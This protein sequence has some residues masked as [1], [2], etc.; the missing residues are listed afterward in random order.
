MKHTSTPTTRRPLQKCLVFLM[1]AFFSLAGMNSFAH[2]A[3]PFQ[4][5]NCT[6]GATL[7]VDATIVSADANTWYAWQYKDNTGTWKCFT[8]S[9]VINGVTFTGITGVAATGPANNAP[10]L[11]I[12]NATLALEGVLVRVLM[13]DGASPCTSPANS[14]GGDGLAPHEG[15]SVSLHVYANSSDCGATTPGCLNNFLN[16]AGAYYGGFEARTYSSTTDSYT[17]LNFG[18]LAGASQLSF[19][20]GSTNAGDFLNAA[21]EFGVMNNP[22]LGWNTFGYFAPHSGNAQ[23]VVRGNTTATS[24]VWYKSG[25]VVVP[26]N[27]Y[28]FSAWAARVDGT[29]PTIQLNFTT[30][31]GTTEVAFT[32]LNTQAVGQWVYIEGEYTVPAGITAVE[33][34]I[35]DKNAG[36]GANNYSLD[37]ICFKQNIEGSIG[38]RVW[39]DTDRDGVQ[40]GT[41]V[42]VAGVTVGLYNSSNQLIASVVTDAYGNYLF[43]G[44]P[45]STTG[46]NYQVRFS[47]PA[48]YVFSGQSLGGNTTLDSDPSVTTGRTGN[49]LLTTAA[50]D[51]TDIDAGIYYSIPARI[52]DFV[53][54]DTDKDGVQDAG[55]PGIAGV[56][57]TLYSGTTPVRTTITDNNGYYLFSDV[58]AGSYTLG[59][60]RPIGYILSTANVGNDA[61]DSDFDPATQK[62]AS[63]SVV[64]GTSNLTFD[65]GLQ[66]TSLTTVA[67]VGDKV[68]NDIDNDGLQDAN[69]PGVPGVTVRL[70][71]SAN[72][73]TGTMITDEFGNYM[74]NN[75][76]PGSYYVT[77]TNLPATF[78]FVAANVGGS[79]NTY[80][81]SDVITPGT[82]A[83]AVFNLLGGERKI[84]IDAG[85]RSSSTT[86]NSS[87]GDF[88]WYDLNKDGLQTAGEGGVPGVTATLYNS[89]TGAV[90][91][92]TTTNS[93]GF[94][95]FTN[96]AVGSYTVG[97]TNLPTGYLF[98]TKD[99][100]ADGIDS[101]VDPNSGRTGV[102]TIATAGTNN[103]TVDGGIKSDPNVRNGKA[104]IGDKVW[105]DITANNVQDADEPGVA[106]V[107]VTLYAGNG[108]TVVATTTTD[109]LG[110]YIFT[111]LDAGNYVVGFT[112]PSGYSFVTKDAGTNDAKDSDADAAT[113]KTIPVTLAAGEVNLTLDAGIKATTIK[114]SLG[115]RVWFDTDADGVQ[116]AGELSAEGVTVTLLNSASQFVKSTTT[117][118][119]GNYLFT[120][121]D[122]GTYHLVFSNLPAGYS[123]TTANLGTAA[124]NSDPNVNNGKTTAIV[125][126]AGVANREWDMGLVTSSRA[127]LGDYVW[128][129]NDG[130]GIQDANEPGVGGI[131]VTLYNATTGAALA[132][133]VTDASGFYM[134]NNLTAATYN[135]GFSNIP[136]N[137][138]FTTKNA[139]AGTAANTSDANPGTG[140]TD[141]FVLAANTIKTD[142]DAGIV[143]LFAAVG[144]YVWYDINSNGRQD[145]NEP[146]VPGV[147]VKLYNG[148][149]VVASAVTDGAGRYFI[150]NIPVPVGGTSFTIGFSDLPKNTTTFTIKA[151]GVANNT[152]NSD[153]NIATGRTD[154]FTLLPGAID[155]TI[156][157]GII[158]TPGGPLPVVMKPLKGVYV[159]GVSRLTWT[160]MQE[161]GSSHF[162]ILRS[163]DGIN[164]S[165]LGTV[166]AK[167]TSDVQTDYKFNDIKV[168]AGMNY[169]RLKL[170]DR[171]GN[172]QYSNIVALKADI[173]GVIIT[174]VYP[175]PFVNKVNISISSETTTRADVRLFDNSGKL[176]ASKQATLVQGVN[177]IV[178]DD[179]ARLA[180]GVYFIKVQAGDLIHT[181]RISK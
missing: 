128:S 66:V 124:T 101:D 88:V 167:G 171:D 65:A 139:G 98:T 26:G 74:F 173:A 94:Y 154:A 29:D 44:L 151:A 36:S 83:T 43:S 106:D 18:A 4:L 50:K 103:Y 116:D 22:K 75:L 127:A 80:I 158:T 120:D 145:A 129:D 31:A 20:A 123:I 153:V 76:N 71:T 79:A 147:T 164:F 181:Q 133:A 39:E 176:V 114:A 125:L 161:S 156:D 81:D 14:Y 169:Y 96:L 51:R 15:K 135:V 86:L 157:A 57:I 21:G 177:T 92:T 10:L 62:T 155:I 59:I 148:A 99:A 141:N 87:L 113:G 121:L 19:I 12:P 105:N 47:L 89:S 111:N 84:V 72:V 126:A 49:V 63:F 159:D 160:T 149:N 7:L 108:T 40:D 131:T 109:A 146:A 77:F 180:T 115:D 60:T 24:K 1:V 42:G 69:E 162:E 82:G 136:A 130:D 54:N 112:L 58:P 172:F 150:N 53:W 90:I 140:K 32:A 138:S 100:G 95:L 117:D 70:Y 143:T 102:Y 163:A 45:V 170:V 91:K 9:S 178:V 119:N 33:V 38:N 8:A 122:A 179:L 168:P 48:Q 2:R 6:V 152:N 110:Y 25:L 104:S 73:L 85:I 64:A 11:S 132:T 56:T 35:R 52:G 142:V 5:T 28:T 68:W 61:L 17:D 34:S 165:Y 174:G 175:T 30:T 137:A 37:D 27:T 55:E 118:Q 46:I 23:M 16:N 93:A 78:N 41:E 144:D 97:F 166:T 13:R 107:T 3:E 67:A 134:F